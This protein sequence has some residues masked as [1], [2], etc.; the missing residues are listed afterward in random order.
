MPNLRRREFLFT[1]AGSLAWAQD[2]TF[3]SRTDVV[4]VPVSVRDKQGKFV[5]DLTSEAFTVEEEG[6]PQTLRYFD[7]QGASLPLHWGCWSTSVPARS[8]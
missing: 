5:S 7:R 1:A 2:L 4:N 3:T 8:T 6:R